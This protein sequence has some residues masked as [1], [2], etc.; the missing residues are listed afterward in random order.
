MELKNFLDPKNIIEQLD[1]AKGSAVADFGCGSGFFSLAFAEIIGESGKVHSFD[2]LP[3][4]LESVASKAKLAGISN[5]IPERANLEKESGSKLPSESIDWVIMKDMLFQ[6][7]MKSIVIKEA[8]RVLKNGGKILI[9][10]W[11]D[12]NAPVGPDKKIRISKEELD[13]L[14]KAQGFKKEK[15]LITGDFHHGAVYTK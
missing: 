1:I 8:F 13:S 3:A 7:K 9:V 5:I 15:D 11:N 2:I 14:A 4:A 12:Q 6:N 10:E